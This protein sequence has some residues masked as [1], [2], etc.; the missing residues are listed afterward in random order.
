[1][2][3]LRCGIVSRTATYW[4]L[5]LMA[6]DGLVELVELGSTAAG[7]D[8]LLGDRVDCAATCPDELMASGA[9]LRIGAGLVAR[10]PTSLLA[11]ASFDSV[12]S[13]RGARIATT[14]ARGSVS[15]FLR[16]FLRAAGLE[17]R[18]YTQVAVG[19]TPAQADALERGTVDAAMVTFP[20]DERLE[21][22][23]SRKLAD[24][25][26][27]L[28]PCAFTTINVREGWT[29]SEEWPAFRGALA[30][31]M[32]RLADAHGRARELDALAE[33]TRGEVRTPP[34]VGYDAAVDLA[35]VERLIAF[36]RDDGTAVQGGAA[37]HV[38]RGVTARARA[39]LPGGGPG[40][41]A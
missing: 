39:W 2:S 29:R 33:G 5:Y 6:R 19:P 10:P 28:G 31:A 3:P 15:T 32:A 25:G 35:A 12:A 26:D 16:A 18:D 41:L 7:V 17:P 30:G 24:V 11:R 13:L 37:A 34:R 22:S 8:A 21:R 38:E 9:P 1:M 14:S 23:G 27:Q 36:M 4:P 20:F 40:D